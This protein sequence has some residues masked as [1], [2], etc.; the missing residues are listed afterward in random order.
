[1]PEEAVARIMEERQALLD[2]KQIYAGP[3]VDRDG[4]ERVAAGEVIGDGDLWG[5]DW[6]LPGVIAQ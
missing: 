6:F 2:G 4:V 3:L 5:M 1:M